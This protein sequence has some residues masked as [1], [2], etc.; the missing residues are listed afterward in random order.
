MIDALTSISDCVWLRPGE[1]VSVVLMK[2]AF[3]SL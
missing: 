2:S 3:R 1:R